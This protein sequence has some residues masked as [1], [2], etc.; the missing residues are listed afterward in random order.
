MIF[1]ENWGLETQNH[2]K[3]HNAVCFYRGRENRS[4]EGSKATG[5]A[6]KSENS[7]SP[8]DRNEVDRGNRREPDR[9]R[10]NQVTLPACST[11]MVLKY[12]R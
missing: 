7:I 9:S 11:V 1:A 6:R 2:A 10:R 5:S 4:I 12:P 8:S 3:E